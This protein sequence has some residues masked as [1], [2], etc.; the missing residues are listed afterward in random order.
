MAK[1]KATFDTPE[2]HEFVDVPALEEGTMA[3]IKSYVVKNPDHNTD[4]VFPVN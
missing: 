3:H 4:L 1:A 2:L